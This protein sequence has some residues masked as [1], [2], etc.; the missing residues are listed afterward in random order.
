MK[1][2]LKK[3]AL[4]AVAA[5]LTVGALEVAARLYLVWMADDATLLRYGT[6]AQKEGTAMQAKLISEFIIQKQLIKTKAP[7][8]PR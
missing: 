6:L 5:L 7:A 4:A 8:I 2:W 3:I 1:P